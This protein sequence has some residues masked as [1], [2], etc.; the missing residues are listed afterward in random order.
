MGLLIFVNDV[1]N[2]LV[3]IALVEGEDEETEEEEVLV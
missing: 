3:H 1:A 2:L